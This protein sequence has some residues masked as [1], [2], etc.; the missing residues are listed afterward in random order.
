[1]S[2]DDHMNSLATLVIIETVEL[3]KILKQQ[4]QDVREKLDHLPDRLFLKINEERIINKI[5]EEIRE[6]MI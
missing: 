5:I 4:L 2:R 1:M 6:K 3:R